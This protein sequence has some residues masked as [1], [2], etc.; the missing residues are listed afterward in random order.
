MEGVRHYAHTLAQN[1]Y[2]LE[3]CT[4]YRDDRFKSEWRRNLCIGALYSVANRYKIRI[5]QVR[6][7]PEHVHM[8]VEL[9]PSMSPSRAAAL[10]KGYS[11]FLVRKHFPHLAKEKAL[12]GS[13]TFIRSVGSVTS[14]VI[15]YYISRSSKN[16]YVQNPQR[17]L[18]GWV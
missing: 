16:Q 18:T 5:H 4:K 17:S 8:F 6:V 3:W 15:D 1:L 2:H 14:D 13:G 10:L 9:R 12:W 7:L 11:S